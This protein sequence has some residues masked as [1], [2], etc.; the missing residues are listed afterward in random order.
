[1]DPQKI[2]TEESKPLP[3]PEGKSA[4]AGGR[5]NHIAFPQRAQQAPGGGNIRNPGLRGQP[6]LQTPV[7]KICGERG[8]GIEIMNRN[9]MPGL[10]ELDGPIK[11]IG[12]SVAH[13]G[14]FHANLA[15]PRI[16]E[17]NFHLKKLPEQRTFELC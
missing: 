11:K 10:L 3:K 16:Y 7:Q 4:T 12:W 17:G 9:R 6:S 2:R 5:D 1:M 14:G 13:P 15:P 8:S